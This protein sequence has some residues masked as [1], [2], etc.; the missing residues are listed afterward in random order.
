ML[1]SL[2]RLPRRTA[3][4]GAMARMLTLLTLLG[5]AACWDAEQQREGGGVTIPL[6]AARADKPLPLPAITGASDPARPLVV[7]DPGHGGRDPGALSP[8]GGIL[9]KDVTLAIARAIRDDLAA[10]GRMRVAL[11]RSGDSHLSLQ[12]RYEVARRL[13]ADLFISLHADAAQ[14]EGARGASIYTLSEVASDREAAQLA[15]RE[16]GSGV[17]GAAAPTGDSGVDRILIDLAQREAMTRS[18][19][20]ARLLHREASPLI[21]FQPDYHRFASLV[22]LK[23]PDIPSILFETGYLTNEADV[24]F[25]GSPEGRRR[26]AQG[27]RKAMEIHFA[28]RSGTLSRSGK[29]PGQQLVHLHGCLRECMA[30]PPVDARL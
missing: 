23:A 4:M 19:D 6:G 15:A 30:R 8:F 22:V 25:L 5:L 12:D 3:D 29:E 13:G 27:V 9:E 20:F 14:R 10:S 17:E 7:I 16:N 1:F 21:P 2:D 26:I 18:A 24:A 11:T 28:R